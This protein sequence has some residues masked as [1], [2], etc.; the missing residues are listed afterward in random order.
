MALNPQHPVPRHVAVIM[1]GNGRWAAA[2]G[3]PRAAGHREGTKAVRR[4]IEAAIDQGVRYVT[5]FAF[6][7]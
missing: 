7:S 5:L 6:S 2:R 4:I 3:L 1:D